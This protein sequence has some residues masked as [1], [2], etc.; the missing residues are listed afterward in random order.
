MAKAKKQ[1]VKPKSFGS[2]VL[3]IARR[4]VKK[5]LA[6]NDLLLKLQKIRTSK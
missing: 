2:E 6:E 4:A 5:T 3:K 1:K